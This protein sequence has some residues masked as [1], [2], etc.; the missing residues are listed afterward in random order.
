MR[1]R[2]QKQNIKT[3]MWIVEIGKWL[4]SAPVPPLLAVLPTGRNE[5][6]WVICI[7]LLFLTTVFIREN[8]HIFFHIQIFLNI[9]LTPVCH[10]LTF[11]DKLGLRILPLYFR[12]FLSSFVSC[13]Q[14][15]LSWCVFCQNLKKKF[16]NICMISSLDR[17]SG[18]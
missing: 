16:W 15:L 3:L 17:L 11:P 9:L 8:M 14:S 18:R 1:Y 13:I 2:Q 6:A 10:F 7:S 12:I 5:V 4:L